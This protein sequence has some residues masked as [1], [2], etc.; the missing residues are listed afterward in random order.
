MDTSYIVVALIAG[1]AGGLISALVIVFAQLWMARPRRSWAP[2]YSAPP[3]AAPARER[4]TRIEG[5]RG[6]FDRFNDRAKRVLAA[7]RK[8]EQV[9]PELF[10]MAL[11]DEGGG[12]GAQVLA[13]F[14]ATAARIRE[15]V[16]GPPS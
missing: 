7:K 12:V 3:G 10:L 14:G 2:Y 11:T 13:S 1:L 6:P 16:D 15:I 9:P 4:F 5:G 8:Q